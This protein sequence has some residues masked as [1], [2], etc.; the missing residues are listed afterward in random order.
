MLMSNRNASKIWETTITM[1]AI[2][3]IWAPMRILAG[4][5]LRIRLTAA[6]E[7]ATTMVTQIVITKAVCILPVTARAEQ[8]PSTPKV[9]GLR[10]KIGSHSNSLVFASAICMILRFSAVPAVF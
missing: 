9:T 6:L 4:I 2:M 3:V 5:W 8:M 7:Q 10:L 1:V